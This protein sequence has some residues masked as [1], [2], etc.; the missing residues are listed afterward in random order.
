MRVTV[1]RVSS[2]DQAGEADVAV[3]ASLDAGGHGEPTTLARSLQWAEAVALTSVLVLLGI[4]VLAVVVSVI[5][6]AAP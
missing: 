4:S 6:L 3:D 5:A 2:D 1:A